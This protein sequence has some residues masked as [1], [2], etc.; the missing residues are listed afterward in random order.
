[1][2]SKTSNPDVIRELNVLKGI[3]PFYI[4]NKDNASFTEIP[5][6]LIT[7]TGELKYMNN[8]NEL[9]SVSS[10]IIECNRIQTARWLNHLWF[11]DGYGKYRSFKKHVS[12]KYNLQFS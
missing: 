8:N 10:L 6:I 1:M 12:E 11:K 3:V 9:K 4:R 2:K 5:N 7:P